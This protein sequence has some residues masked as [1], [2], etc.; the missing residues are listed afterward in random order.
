[1]QFNAISR[2]ELLLNQLASLLQTERHD[3]PNVVGIR[4]N[5]SSNIGL[6]NMFNHRCFWQTRRIMNFLCISVLVVN[7]IRYVGHGSDDLHIE[8]SI[9][10]FLH[11]FHVQK[12][13]ESTSEAKT[14]CHRRFRRERQ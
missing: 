12:S 1:M 4:N 2:Y 7:H 13:Q 11:D 8:L 5:G 10:T 3:G 14:K 9:Q 6:F